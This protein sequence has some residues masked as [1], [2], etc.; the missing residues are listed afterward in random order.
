M[1][2]VTLVIDNE[3]TLTTKILQTQSAVFAIKKKIFCKKQTVCTLVIYSSKVSHE[4][5][6]GSTAGLISPVQPDKS[7]LSSFRFF[8]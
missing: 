2:K 4:L 6:M 8:T 3:Y 5:P 1:L 7:T